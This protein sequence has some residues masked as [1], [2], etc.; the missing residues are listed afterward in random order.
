MEEDCGENND[1]IW[2]AMTEGLRRLPRTLMVVFAH[3]LTRSVF[4]H[5]QVTGYN[6]SRLSPQYGKPNGQASKHLISEAKRVILYTGPQRQ[7]FIS[8]MTN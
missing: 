6:V 8:V 7:L 4:Q 3:L 1:G 2:K 5:I